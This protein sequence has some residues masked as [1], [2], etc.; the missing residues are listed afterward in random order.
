MLI[1]LQTQQS[2]CKLFDLVQL[3]WY[4][5]VCT[6]HCS[7]RMCAC[8][9][10]IPAY[11]YNSCC[12]YELQIMFYKNKQVRMKHTCACWRF[13]DVLSDLC[14]GFL[15]GVPVFTIVGTASERNC[16][17]LGAKFSDS[18]TKFRS[19]ESGVKWSS[20]TT[21]L[22]LNLKVSNLSFPFFKFVIHNLHNFL[23]SALFSGSGITKKLLEHF[24][25]SFVQ[26]N[27][28]HDGIFRWKFT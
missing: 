25:F 19:K 10:I 16:F 14:R 21:L 26:L 11:K 28:W 5:H 9:I 6:A 13:F 23:F 22:L 3:S 15:T 18:F 24:P 17:L 12:K 4:L 20:Q 27:A 7:T 2:A 1:C 8:G